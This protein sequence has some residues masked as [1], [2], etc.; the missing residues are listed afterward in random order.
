MRKRSKYRPKHVLVNPVAYAV[1]SVSTV[2]SH[3]KFLLELKIKNSQAM[4]ALTHGKATKADMDMLIAMS[5]MTEALHGLGFGEE[6]KEVCIG[7][8]EALISIAYRAK[9]HGRFTPTG[10]EIQALQLLMELHD[11][12][13][14]VITVKDIERAIAVVE[15]KLARDKDTIRLPAAPAA[16]Q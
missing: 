5:N 13:M 6:Y 3:K 1:E 11:A 2:A 15:G 16:L 8:R 14:D 4:Y 7:G 9:E 10:P 12:Q